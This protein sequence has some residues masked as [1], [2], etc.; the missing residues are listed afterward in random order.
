[1][2]AAA[3]GILLALGSALVALWADVRF[4]QRRPESPVRRMG[5]SFS[6]FA[7]LQLVS[8]ATAHLSGD[9]APLGQRVAV[10]FLLF[11]PA[12]VYA[13]V[14]GVWVLRSLVDVTRLARR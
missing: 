12:L 2:D 9:G 7:V 13:F 8:V 1:M 3:F 6:A 5:H 11:A 4:E 10:L 14:A